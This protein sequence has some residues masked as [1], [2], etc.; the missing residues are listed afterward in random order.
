[1]TSTAP[2]RRWSAI[3]LTG[4]ICSLGGV[5]ACG[6]RRR[7]ER[8]FDSNATP[9]QGAD[10]AAIKAYLLDH[11]DAPAAARP[12]RCARDAEAYYAL[13]EGADFDYEAL[14]R[15]P[16]RRGRA[17]SSSAARS[18]FAARQPGLRGDGGRRRRRARR[19]PTTT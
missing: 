16:A 9:A 1:M 3:A 5:T 19:S 11:T 8:V 12:R 7:A 15:R 6:G 4:L 14:L 18:T 10:L 17:R 13:A 2:A